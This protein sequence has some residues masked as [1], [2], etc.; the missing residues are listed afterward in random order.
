[1]WAPWTI[2]KR[3]WGAAARTNFGESSLGRE[4][5][6]HGSWQDVTSGIGL[7]RITASSVEG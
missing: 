6:S 3:A 1:M 7:R 5:N 4:G 2:L